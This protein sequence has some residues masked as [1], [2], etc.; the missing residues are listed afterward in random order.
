MTFSFLNQFFYILLCLDKFDFIIK[1]SAHFWNLAA[2]AT[3]AAGAAIIATMKIRR[4]RRMSVNPYLL[5]RKNKGRFNKD[6]RIS[7]ENK[8]YLI[9]EY[10]YFLCFSSMT[11][12]HTLR[13]LKRISIWTRPHLT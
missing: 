3:A 5:E 13:R 12:Q 6:V 9:Y 1:M 10:C 4:D 8:K 7:Y 11:W 2:V